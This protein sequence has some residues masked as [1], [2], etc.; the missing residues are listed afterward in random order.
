MRD[1][2]L[3]EFSLL[4][5]INDLLFPNGLHILKLDMDNKPCTDI[6]FKN[7]ECIVNT[8]N[9]EIP[10]K[11]QITINELL[12]HNSDI[13]LLEI[14]NKYVYFYHIY[15]TKAFHVVLNI[16]TQEP[17]SKLNEH[18]LTGM[19]Q[20]Y[21]NF[22]ELLSEGQTDQLTGL[23]N[24]KTF[25]DS[26]EKLFSLVSADSEKF[27]NNKRKDCNC[28]HWI[29]MVDIDDFKLINDKLGHIFG[30]EV[31][32]L[33]TQT[34][35]TYFRSEDMIFR[36]GGEEFV[37]I[38]NNLNQVDCRKILERFRKVIENQYFPQVGQVTVSLGACR[39]S[40]ESYSVTLI[41]YADKA[42][43]HSKKNGKNQLTFFEDLVALGLEKF[44]NIQTGDIVLF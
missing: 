3:M 25:D 39:L 32:I 2:E 6:Y 29:I 26:I 12:L 16:I 15:Q 7:T 21:Q 10:E 4:K 37:F 40:R 5:T 23:L 22:C 11:M 38:L 42:L 43:Y 44:E 27:P 8:E 1:I 35:K 36:F 20:I 24:R 13:K 19:L 17:L 31:L 34:M 14:D 30:D 41:D 33:L 18:L 9:I 28:G